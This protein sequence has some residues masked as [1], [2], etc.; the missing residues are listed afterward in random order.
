MHILNAPLLAD[1]QD[2]AG[3][4]FAQAAATE[5]NSDAA[6]CHLYIQSAQNLSREP[7]LPEQATRAYIIHKL[8]V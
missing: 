2:R 6:K 4:A 3:S 7:V 5:A 1:R 8:S